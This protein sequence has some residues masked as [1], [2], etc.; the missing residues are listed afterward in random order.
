MGTCADTAHVPSEFLVAIAA[1]GFLALVCR[2]VFATDHRP[3]PLVP[4]RSTGDYGLLVPVATVR[5]RDDA[6]MLREVLTAAGIQ[7]NV[8]AGELPEEYVVLVF[9]EDL[10]RA[11]QLVATR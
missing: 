8:T 1:M 5:T 9:R 7:A 3:A 6:D 4:R 10:P 11:R 2:W